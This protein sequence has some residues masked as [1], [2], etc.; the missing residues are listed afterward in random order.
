MAKAFASH[1]DLADKQVTFAR[2]SENAYAYTTVTWG[3]TACIEHSGASN[4]NPYVLGH[5]ETCMPYSHTAYWDE[6][7]SSG[8]LIGV[9]P[10]MGNAS[11]ISCTITI[12][13]RFSYSDYASRGDN[14]DVNC[15]RVVN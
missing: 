12:D 11:W 1:A 8:Q 3:G 7:R 5:G 15:L 9:D 10:I 6:V 13:G 4:G 2:L 14:T